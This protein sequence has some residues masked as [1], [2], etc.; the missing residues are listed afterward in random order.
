MPIIV[1]C[2]KCKGDVEIPERER[3]EMLILGG[4]CEHKVCPQDL[5]QPG[6]PTMNLLHPESRGLL[7]GIRY[8]L[9]KRPN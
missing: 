5:P 9:R 3:A 8:L 6:Q 4:W 2:R 1:Q 7:E